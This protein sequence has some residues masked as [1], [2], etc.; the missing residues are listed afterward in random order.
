[1]V[2]LVGA[3]VYLGLYIGFIYS[4]WGCILGLVYWGG[5]VCIFEIC[6]SGLYIGVVYWSEAVYPGLYIG[7][8]Y[9]GWA[10]YL[11]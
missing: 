6:I 9:L 10:A 5:A 11:A 2:Y 8:V 7:V 4:G 1:M 3:V